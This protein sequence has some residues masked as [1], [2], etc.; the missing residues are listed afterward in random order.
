MGLVIEEYRGI[1]GVVYAPLVS[2]TL[3]KIEHGTVKPLAGVS[4]LSKEVSSDSATHYY[5]NVPAI[6]IDSE[7]PDEVKINTSLIPMETLA[8]I[9]GQHY[10]P[11]LNMLVEGASKPPYLA[12]GYITETTSGDRI[13]VW[14]LKGKFSIPGSTHNTKDDGTDANG[15][16]ITYT[17]INTTHKFEKT[18]KTAKAIVINETRGNAD[19]SAFWE[20]VQTP[21]TVKAKVNTPSQVSAKTAK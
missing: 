15:Q 20:S 16:E 9:T 8:D 1:E 12:L 14:R 21:D 6:V 2:D 7:G 10:D 4:E 3:E 5:D 11:D 17:G 18:G 19:T 13:L